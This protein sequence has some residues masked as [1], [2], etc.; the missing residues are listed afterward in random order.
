[1]SIQLRHDNVFIIFHNCELSYLP[2]L[3]PY[4]M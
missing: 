2:Y 1:M 4:E 3:R